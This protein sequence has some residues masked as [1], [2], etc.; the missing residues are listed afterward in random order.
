MGHSDRYMHK[1]LVTV[2]IEKALFEIG[3]PAYEAVV[4]A[5]QDA[6]HCTI[7]DCYEHPEYLKNVLEQYFGA[8]SSAVIQSINENLDKS[9]K[10]STIDHFL[11]IL[12]K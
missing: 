1:D 3:T 8:A 2:T 10:N 6:Y 11:F 9:A 5:L 7:P 4:L 12:N